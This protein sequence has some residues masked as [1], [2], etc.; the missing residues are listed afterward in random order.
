MQ[1][2]AKNTVGQNTVYLMFLLL[3]FITNLY[4]LLYLN[5]TFWIMNL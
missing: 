4:F 5:F 3:V 2:G 1:N